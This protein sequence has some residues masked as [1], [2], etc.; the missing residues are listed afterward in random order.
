MD[1]LARGNAKKVGIELI[2]IIEKAAPAGAQLIVP[3]RQRALEL[4]LVP[5]AVRHF[6]D[7]LLPLDQQFPKSIQTVRAGKATG[8]ANNSN[9]LRGADGIRRR[10]GG[11]RLLPG[12][13]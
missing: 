10:L 2:H 9:W 6:A 8:H 7:S 5:T 4:G 3:A 11:G 12:S 13:W 1:G